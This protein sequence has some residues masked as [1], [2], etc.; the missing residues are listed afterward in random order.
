MLNKKGFTLIEI[1]IITVIV[2]I[3]AVFVFVVL[4]NAREKSRDAVRLADIKQARADLELSFTR[5]NHYPD[6]KDLKI[7]KSPSYIYQAC[8]NRGDI[9]G[10]GAAIIDNEQASYALTY[11]LKSN[12]GDLGAGTHV[13]TLYGIADP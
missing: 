7:L 1:L 10:D 4:N 6:A 3:L 8:D 2:I 13:A 5:S 12:N 9:C 11:I